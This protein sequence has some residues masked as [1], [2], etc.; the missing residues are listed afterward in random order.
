MNTSEEILRKLRA[1]EPFG[2]IRTEVHSVSK[3]YEV[4]GQF[5]D[6]QQTRLENTRLQIRGAEEERDCLEAQ[7]ESLR[8]ELEN[9]RQENQELEQENLRLNSE[10]SEK[11]VKLNSLQERVDEFRA[12]G[13]TGEIMDRLEPM[14]KRGGEKLLIQVQNVEKYGQT[15]RNYLCLKKKKT[16]L[17]REIRDLKNEKKKEKGLWF[18]SDV[19]C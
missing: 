15:L 19:C 10:L 6:E 17:V 12:Q 16:S 13:F 8:H 3:L 5:L 18:W 2:K 4:G 11:T 7:V 14:V 9:S 1:G